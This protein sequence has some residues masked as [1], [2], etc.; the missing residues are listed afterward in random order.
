MRK[1]YIFSFVMF[2]GVQLSF[3]QYNYDK[4]WQK[5][6]ELEL[7]GKVASAQKLVERIYNE[8]HKTQETTQLV[9]SFLYRAKF[10]LLLSEDA[11]V[12]VL[13]SLRVEIDKQAF[14]TNAILENIYASLLT[15]YA[16]KYQYKIRKRSV[17]QSESIP[18]DVQLWDI[19]TFVTEIHKHFQH[20]I[21]REEALLQ[22][23][24]ENYMT[25]L[26]GNATM[27]IYRSS[28]Y[29]ILAHNALDFYETNIPYAYK[30][31]EN[32]RIS[33]KDYTP[34]ETFIQQKFPENTQEVFA[35][36]NTLQLFQ[37]LEKVAL[38]N[39]NAHVDV[40]L[41]RLNFILKS[42]QNYSKKASNYTKALQ[43][44][45][46]NYQNNPLEALINY[47]LANHYFKVSQRY[48]YD[49][50]ENSKELR[51]KAI[52]L[53]K[54]MTLAHPNSEGGIK[55]ALLQKKIAQKSIKST[56]ETF[57]I[58]NKATLAQVEIKNIDT[59]YLKVYRAPHG[60]LENVSYV[61]RD[62]LVNDFI[63]YKQP[64][65][66]ETY[67]TNIPKD[68][69]KHTTEINIPSL[70]KG[71]YLLV[72]SD[73]EEGLTT[74]SVVSYN[75]IQKTNLSEIITEYNDKEVH[76]ILHRDTGKPIHKAKIKI[77]DNKGTVK[78]TERTNVYGQATINKRS[79]YK[80]VEKY[81][82]HQEDTLYT[83]ATSLGK[84]YE[85]GEQEAYWEAKPFVFTDRAMYRPGQT[86]YF[87]VV[88]IQQKNGVSSVVPNVFCEVEVDSED[89]EL[90]LLR[91]KTNEFGSFSGS[92][93]IPKSSTTGEFTIIV[94]EDLDYE[95]EEHPFWDQIDEFDTAEHTF[96]VEEYKRPRFEV[97]VDPVTSNVAFNDT[98]KVTG[99][100]K[101]LLGSSLT[102]A[103]VSYKITRFINAYKYNSNEQ[104]KIIVEAKTKTDNNG[105]FSIPFV[106][107]IDENVAKKDTYAYEYT[108][109][110]EVTDINGET[111]TAEKMVSVST[112]GFTLDLDIPR[113]SNK[114]LP[115]K[116]EITTKDINDVNVAANGHFK[117]YKLTN[118]T[119]VYKKR[120]WS[121]PDYYIIPKETFVQQF[122]H[123][124]YDD[125]EEAQE[126]EAQITSMP[127]NTGE[128]STFTLDVSSWE[129]GAYMIENAVYDEKTK[130]SITQSENFVL[131]DPD[132][133]YLANNALFDYEIR[134]S[135][136]KN[137]GF[138]KLKLATALRDDK[139]NVF[140]Q[141]FHE[142]EQIFSSMESVEKGSKIV[143]IPLA[144][145]LTNEV[146][147]RMS[148]VKFNT[149]YEDEFS[150]LL[151]EDK[152][153]L[154]IETTTFRNKLQPGQLETWQFKVLNLENKG[155]NAEVLASMYDE[156]LDQFKVHDWDVN[157]NRF[158]G[159][160]YAA[161][162]LQVRGFK[163]KRSREIY[164]SNNNYTI[165]TFKKHLKFNWFGLHF[166]NAKY[167]NDQYL[168]NI[169]IQ[170]YLNNTVYT[171]SVSGYV[172]DDT[173]MPLPGASVVIQGTNIGTI[174]NFDGLY[175]INAKASDVLTFSYVGFSPEEVKIG[176]QTNVS[177]RLTGNNALEEVTITAYGI[178]TTKAAVS[179][180][181]ITINGKSIQH[182][183]VGSLDQMLQGMAAGVNINTGSG[184]SGQSA[185]II[186]RGRGSLQG[187]L[188]PLFVIDGVPVDQNVFRNLSDKNITELSVLKG[189]DATAL[190]GNRG[191]N[192]VVIVTTKYGTR[193]EMVGD[194]EVIVGLTEEDIDTVETRKNLQETA[195]FYPHLRTDA[196]GN[197][198]IE[199]EAPEALT[200][201]K[202][203][204]FAHQKNG[205]YGSILK[206]AVTQKELMVVP[207][208]PR[209][210][211]ENDT[212]VIST[213]VVN[214]QNK[215]TK[216]IASLRLYDAQT[217]ESIDAK[218]H[219]TEKNKSFTLDAK[220]NTN[221]SWKLYIPKGI[222]AIQYKVIAT[223]ENFS[224]GEESVLPV[225]K[226]SILITEAKPF[227]VKSREEKTV[228]FSKLATN[229]SETLAQH[230]LT[231]EYTSNPTWSAIQSLPY[232]LEY[233]YECAEQTFARLYANMIAAHI[234]QSS[235]KIKEVFE[236][237]K[238]NGQQISDL[239]KNPEFKS[240][241]LA[242]TPW[243]RDAASET[244][245]KQQLATLFDEN[246][247]NE[248]QQEL[249]YK[250]DNLQTASGG[251]PWFAGGKANYYITLHMLQ[252]YAH[253]VTFNGMT[254]PL[255]ND[256]HQIMKAACKYIDERFLIAHDVLK[257][258]NNASYQQQIEYLYTRTMIAD[259]IE[260]PANVK[261]AMQLYVD[262]LQKDWLFLSVK[263]KA[264]LA[265]SLA[266]MDK[267][268]D[269]KKIMTAL[270]ELAVKSTEN[271]MYWNEVTKRRYD[272][273]SA[274][275]TQALL[276]EAYAEI[277]KDDAI[278]Q[279]LQLWLLQQKQRNQWETT[280]ATTKAI[281][282]LL[283]NPKEFV[284]IKD[285]TKFTIGTEKIKTKK[286]TESEKE[287]GTGYFKTSWYKDEITKDKSKI[288]IKNNGK[289]VGFGA[290]YWQYFETLNN[291][292]QSETAS[293]QVS[294]ALYVKETVN[295]EE[296]LVPIAKKVLKIGDKITVRLTIQNKDDVE[297]IHLK[298][299]RAA[300]LESINV[301]S[302]YKWQ[303]GV[304]YYESTRDASTNFFFDRIPKGV[305]ILEYEVRVNNT[306]N[307][308]NGIT[309]I[310]SMYAP[311]LRSHTKGIRVNVE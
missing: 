33:E 151:Y 196:E 197:I 51:T 26:E 4:K 39:K 258:S 155:S 296:T 72:L 194:T 107:T 100:A 47:E 263:Q 237:W 229:K 246:A 256:A 201:W 58:P 163:T 261:E 150:I 207:N 285:H 213:K 6:E 275:E 112:S 287:A 264:M 63:K 115:L 212:I 24:V 34:T 43:Q 288:N 211:R 78:Q 166:Q 183:P 278:V 128:K 289:T 309:T 82:I 191:A 76:T 96:T 158:R 10:S 111:Q 257:T 91:L 94:D 32:Y 93:K 95:E 132:D 18:S 307:F 83:A 49:S 116:V 281:Y 181:V 225:L 25:L 303:D 153:Y 290:V 145:Q 44:L 304:G 165:P 204:L 203:Q 241:L 170:Q 305:F 105:N 98:I 147:I 210:L 180:K 208:M 254:A 104:E 298:D 118:P 97:T 215:A 297:F 259:F 192:G 276:I 273:T 218:V 292:T 294:K 230:Q 222:E 157:F 234:L 186:I 187:D 167:A 42:T 2:L 38:K 1:I 28:L 260:I 200:R 87:K 277:T 85:K 173:G 121:V 41:K 271:G 159:N 188:E 101:A 253:L 45:G 152:N 143:T 156:S 134:N 190:Y 149:F 179:S 48:Y 114:K 177:V 255:K 250:L 88:V 283:L 66:Q 268:S 67:S 9:K 160:Y 248:L 240:L 23:P 198:A 299:M 65:L 69:Y 154:N 306:G 120:P 119:R 62:S 262:N 60:L 70:P 228:I 266:R 68:Y 168:T 89:G 221:L 174:T 232:L 3:A 236:A 19:K 224:D 267:Q 55:C 59:I 233:P 162:Q 64:T 113:K 282:A 74:T 57:S 130:D 169:K 81:I 270:D 205:I 235:P 90:K 53:T 123:M 293:L 11:E 184:D 127:F 148:F 92:F 247:L 54:A 209:F 73:D 182:V 20:S 21:S 138:I 12:Q 239:E 84:K 17:V 124:S 35:M 189:A 291:V 13:Q 226:N 86:V 137:D 77:S 161:P 37:K 280:K 7:E 272:T 50:N 295:G 61:K 193:K 29:E 302:E 300:G 99:N 31:N 301:L 311:A 308:S 265:L 242:E 252:T 102:N 274:V 126:K 238:A 249:W 122:P 56:V 286:L 135:D 284:S 144:K 75:S 141:A 40:V 140:V 171:G 80:T 117:I 202:F 251:F 129:S 103:T 223:A 5:V 217:M 15:Q 27:H 227:V 243:L 216:G 8:A 46:N 178:S 16:R 219:L 220:G 79:R 269:A 279:E 14:P 131:I 106:A 136:Y 245:K 176:S 52:A 139:L 214:L 36:S 142:S 71:N 175:S 195:F 125:K 310:E 108:V 146:T 172:V 231:L 30:S 109:S 110:I 133:E 244:Q 22:L 185:N 206:N 199:F 164:N